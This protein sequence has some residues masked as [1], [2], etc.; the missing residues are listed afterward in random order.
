MKEFITPII[1]VTKNKDIRS[2]FTQQEYEQWCLNNNTSKFSIKYYKGLGTST[3]KEAREYFSRLDKHILRF[4]YTSKE[5]DES[6]DLAFNKKKADER[7]E[8]IS[9]YDKDV[10][11][12][13]S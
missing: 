6:I 1:K 4:K 2:F 3:D 5:D 9:T 10:C 8:W 11:I 7:K 13:H 12:D